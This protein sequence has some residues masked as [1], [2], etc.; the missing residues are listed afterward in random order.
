MGLPE[1]YR[2]RFNEFAER[3]WEAMGLAYDLELVE[4]S[5]WDVGRAVGEAV[6]QHPV[7]QRLL[8]RRYRAC[9]REDWAKVIGADWTADRMALDEINDCDDFAWRFKAHLA[10]FFGI[11]AI[12]FVIDDAGGHAYNWVMFAEGDWEWY[13]PQTRR[14]V[15]LGEVDER[16]DAHYDLAAGT[17]IV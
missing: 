12:G 5:R 4:L 10:E 8:D 9:R 17:V 3:L 2:E 7:V 1:M 13:E 15:H 16:I 14:F 11:T 6:G